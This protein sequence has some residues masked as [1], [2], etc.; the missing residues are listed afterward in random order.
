MKEK[1]EAVIDCCDDLVVA[2][3]QLIQSCPAVKQGDHLGHFLLRFTVTQKHHLR[4]MT[5]L[6]ENSMVGEAIIILRTMMEGATLVRWVC[7]DPAPRTEMWRE[8]PAVV[9]WYMNQMRRRLGLEEKHVE[10]LEKNKETM[11]RLFLKKDARKQKE[12]GEPLRDKPYFEKWY[13]G[14][15]I[16][17]IF[18][19]TWDADLEE[20]GQDSLGLYEIF[21]H[22]SSWVHWD[23]KKL[24]VGWDQDEQGWV[25][26]G[27]DYSY[28][29]STATGGFLMLHTCLVAA[30]NHFQLSFADSLSGLDQQIR[31]CGS[32]TEKLEQ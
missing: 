27:P 7:H 19:E 24:T 26:R 8:H 32:L 4:A 11:D 25:C 6:I 18:D 15:S 29:I 21:Q 28:A 1:T 30:N 22:A 16:K 17:N 31:R 5:L 12:R 9:E 3:D 23:V 14:G 10:D 13:G 2:A 20:K